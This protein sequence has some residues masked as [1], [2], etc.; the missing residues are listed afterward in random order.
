[1]KSCGSET[2]IRH[3]AVLHPRDFDVFI[4]AGWGRNRGSKE[5]ERCCR[6]PWYR[7]FLGGYVLP[8]TSLSPCKWNK[9]SGKDEPGIPLSANRSHYHTEKFK[10]TAK[11]MLPVGNCLLV[12]NSPKRR[13]QQVTASFFPPS[14]LNRRVW[15]LGKSRQN[16][17]FALKTH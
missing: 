12:G 11:K 13:L 17:C 15:L 2:G 9:I 1:M 4:L 16:L 5:R 10:K 14:R 7:C 8:G 6:R 3:V